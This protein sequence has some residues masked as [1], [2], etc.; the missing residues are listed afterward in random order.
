MIS[1]LSYSK[2]I[3]IYPKYHNSS[4]YQSNWDLAW[5]QQQK[6]KPMHIGEWDLHSNLCAVHTGI[7]GGN[8]H[9]EPNVYRHSTLTVTFVWAVLC[10][11]DSVSVAI[12]IWEIIA[13]LSAATERFNNKRTVFTWKSKHRWRCV[14]FE[15]A[16]HLCVDGYVFFLARMTATIISVGGKLLLLCYSLKK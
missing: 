4:P 2:N 13:R 10:W 15:M 12:A 9:S 5:E 6:N 14:F 7:K 8:T 1:E 16:F 3:T 11:C